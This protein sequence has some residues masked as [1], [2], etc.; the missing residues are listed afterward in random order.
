VAENQELFK[1]ANER[2]EQALRDKVPE[3]QALPFLCECA[4]DTCTS[5]VELKLADYDRVRATDN[6]F[7][8]V[9]GHPMI[10]G[11]HVVEDHGAHVVAEKER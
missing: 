8:I 10:E 6:R 1:Q 5:A 4:D 11:E 2:L 9:A 7:F 3:A